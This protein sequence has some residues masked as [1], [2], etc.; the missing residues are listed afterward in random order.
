MP[1]LP[2]KNAGRIVCEG[3]TYPDAGP[4]SRYGQL[5]VQL[6]FARALSRRLRLAHAR[7]RSVR[8]LDRWNGLSR[9]SRARLLLVRRRDGPNGFVVAHVASPSRQKLFND[10]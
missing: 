5:D 6:P 3:M 1:R 8:G 10:R 9:Y 7:V 4:T 2:G